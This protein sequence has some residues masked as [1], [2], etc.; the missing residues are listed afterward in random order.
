MRYSREMGRDIR[1]ITPEAYQVLAQYRWP[2]NVRELQNVIRR[3]IALAKDNM[4]GLDDLPDEVVAAAGEN[5]TAA[6]DIGYFA[7][8]DQRLAAFELE[9]L[10]DLLDRHEGDVR[11]AALEAKLPRGTLYR[12]MKKHARIARSFARRKRGAGNERLGARVG[13][14]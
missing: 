7:L 13:M 3:G 1:G 2:G 6:G 5:P 9:Y 11:T 14:A 8:R 12:L 10:R 4:I